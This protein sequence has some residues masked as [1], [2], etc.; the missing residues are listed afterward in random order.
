MVASP[1]SSWTDPVSPRRAPRAKVVLP[2]SDKRQAWPPG[3]TRDI[4]FEGMFISTERPLAVGERFVVQVGL[5]EMEV[6]LEVAAEVVHSHEG[7]E[8]PQGKGMGVR[9]LHSGE[10]Q[11]AFF[12]SQVRKLLES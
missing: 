11:R 5:P 8:G 12:A 9:L 1:E 2:V 10:A 6:A 7:S 3:V 4:S